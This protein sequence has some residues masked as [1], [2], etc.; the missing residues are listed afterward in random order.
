MHRFCPNPNESIYS[1][2]YKFLHLPLEMFQSEVLALTEGDFWV[3]HTIKHLCGLLPHEPPSL[4]GI[5]GSCTNL[6]LFLGVSYCEQLSCSPCFSCSTRVVTLRFCLHCWS[7]LGFICPSYV[8]FREKVVFTVSN[9]FIFFYPTPFEAF[10]GQNERDNR[11]KEG[12]EKWAS[13]GTDLS[14]HL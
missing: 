1:Y 11:R 14:I 10:L 8:I 2:S 12:A 5:P 13:L 3:S 7:N 4:M 9:I 6:K